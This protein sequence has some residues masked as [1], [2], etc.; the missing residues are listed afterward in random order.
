MGFPVI[1]HALPYMEETGLF[2]VLHP[3]TVFRFTDTED[4]P[5]VQAF[6]EH[7]AR[8]GH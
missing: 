5:A 4:N 1:I 6:C 8:F 3:Y 2:A 7:P